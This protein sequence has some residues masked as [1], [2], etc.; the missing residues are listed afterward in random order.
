MKKSF[1]VLIAVFTFSMSFAQE[2][3]VKVNPIGILV[4]YA[5][6]GYEFTVKETQTVTVSAL[7]YDIS[8]VN[9]VG[10]NGEYRFYFDSGEAL[11]GWHAGP[12][13]GFISF[14]N[15][16]STIT[17]GGEAGHQ[18]ILGENFLIDAFVGVNLLP[19]GTITN[20]V[21]IGLGASIGYAW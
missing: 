9:G 1:L 15:S 18:W 13:V 5:N 8:G 20:S 3:A 16:S 6:A 21:A 11:K 4:G 2:Q 7:F 12:N 19:G 14:N 10:V 17:F